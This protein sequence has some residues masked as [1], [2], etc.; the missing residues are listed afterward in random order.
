VSASALD[1]V[2]A[3]TFRALTAPLIRCAVPWEHAAEWTIALQPVTSREALAALYLPWHRRQGSQECWQGDIFN[4]DP[5][6]LPIARRIG[7]LPSFLDLLDE[8]RR[9]AVRRFER[10]YRFERYPQGLIAPAAQAQDG[11]RILLDGC[12]RLSAIF[13][14]E[15]PF[16]L[17][18]LTIKGDPLKLGLV[19]LERL[20][21][22]SRNA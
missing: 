19:D 6:D 9:R 7:E 20:I 21:A 15:V 12:H 3:E 11:R 16:T 8:P 17:A 5:A 14:A 22:E 13:L 18:L 10:G 2:S 1:R 4:P